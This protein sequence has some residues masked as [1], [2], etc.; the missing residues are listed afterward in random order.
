M[1][2]SYGLKLGEEFIES[3]EKKN[4]EQLWGIR[5]VYRKRK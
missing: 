5:E 2:S 3:Y 4:S 1:Q